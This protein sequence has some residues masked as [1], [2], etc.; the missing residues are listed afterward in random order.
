MKLQVERDQLA[1]AVAWTA[2]GLPARPT[3]PVL[4][5]MLLHAGAD[6]T[7]STFDYEISAQATIPVITDEEGTVL[8][9]GRLLAEIVRSLPAKPVELTTDGTRATLKCGSATFTL[10]LLPEEEYPALP[11]MPPLVG[12]VGSDA[13]ASAIGQV[14]IAAG[15]DDTLPALTGIRIEI[16]GDM[17]TMVATD[18]YR[19]AVRELRWN[20][21]RPDLSTAVLVPA[22]VLGDTA[23]A[24]TSGAEVSISLGGDSLIGFTGAGRQ[25]TTRLLSGEYPK[26]QSLLPSEFSAVAELPAGSFAEAVRRVALVA[27]RNT[28]VRLAFSQSQ[29]V[30]EAGASE[31]AQATEILDA[32]F[33]GDDLQI[34]F[35]PHYLLDGIG[36][37]DSDTA[38]ISFTS[39]TKPAV[40]TGKTEGEPDY[41]YVLM[42]IRS[43]G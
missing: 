42:P 20:T 39:P 5:G 35:N 4:A 17:L 8:V 24:L 12:S 10:V 7:L 29:L 16:D 38:R 31:E 37:I 19:L 40:V 6:L 18:R 2:R 36:G 1:E 23:R 11:E 21:A 41:R 26:Y 27:E 14:A 30:L 33:D 3:A 43:A 32:A 15:R 9:S 22:R 34:A 13:L 25:T 28:A